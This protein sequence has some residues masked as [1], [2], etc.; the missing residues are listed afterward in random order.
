[1]STLTDFLIQHQETLGNAYAPVM[2]F[3]ML[4]VISPIWSLYLVACSLL[5]IIPKEKYPFL[6]M[7]C[8]VVRL[9]FDAILNPFALILYTSF[10]PWFFNDSPYIF[11][12]F[13][14]NLQSNLSILPIPYLVS[15][16]VFYLLWYQANHALYKNIKPSFDFHKEYLINFYSPSRVFGSAALMIVLFDF[17]SHIAFLLWSNVYLGACISVIRYLKTLYYAYSTSHHMLTNR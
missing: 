12:F 7:P 9:I 10:I 4:A 6:N 2:T 15:S 3:Y 8:H 5:S 1:M 11:Y 17:D 16:I 13:Y 14:T